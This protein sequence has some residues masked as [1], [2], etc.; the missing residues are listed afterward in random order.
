MKTQQYLNPKYP[1][2]IR[3]NIT[4]L[5]ISKRNLE[6]HLDLR[7]FVNLERLDC[8]KNRLTSLDISNCSKLAQV[9]AYLNEFNCDLSVFACS[10]ELISLDLGF[11]RTKSYDFNNFF[12]SLKS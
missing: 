7:E 8:S 12:G 11:D 2:S 4:Q 5:N 9:V 1:K 10:T 3:K 6:G